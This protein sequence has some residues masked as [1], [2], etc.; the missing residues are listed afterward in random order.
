MCT[1][2]ITC[3]VTHEQRVLH[4]SALIHVPHLTKSCILNLLENEYDITGYKEM[5][6]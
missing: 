1:V 2:V 6:K 3:Q 5:C 4:F